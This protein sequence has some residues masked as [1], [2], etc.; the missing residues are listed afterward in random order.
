MSTAGAAKM[1]EVIDKDQVAGSSAKTRTQSWLEA[2]DREEDC[3]PEANLEAGSPADEFAAD[4]VA[5]ERKFS[6]GV[7]RLSCSL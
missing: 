4:R 7:K 3:F 6:K 1:V 2:V 5:Y